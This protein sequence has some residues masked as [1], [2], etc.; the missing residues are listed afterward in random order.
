MINFD[1]KIIP[2][3]LQ[4]KLKYTF[5]DIEFKKLNNNTLATLHSILIYLQS[6]KLKFV[7]VLR[8]SKWH[9]Q[10]DFAV[11]VL[12]MFNPVSGT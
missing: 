10:V 9:V 11:Q 2:K 5:K 12:I 1:E 8:K 4:L 3:Y 6:Y 7:T